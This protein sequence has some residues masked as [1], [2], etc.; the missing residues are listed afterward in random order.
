MKVYRSEFWTKDK[1]WFS[2]YPKEYQDLTNAYERIRWQLYRFLKIRLPSP[3]VRL[4]FDKNRFKK[5]TGK[6]LSNEWVGFDGED[7]H[8]DEFLFKYGWK[9]WDHGLIDI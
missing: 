4:Q 3:N 2:D 1:H 9:M 5:E 8:T 6:E 7:P